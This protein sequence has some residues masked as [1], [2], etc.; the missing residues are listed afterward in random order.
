MDRRILS[1]NLAVYG[2]LDRQPELKIER[3]EVM[4]KAMT[5]DEE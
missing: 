1:C 5:D 4:A 3:V 2:E